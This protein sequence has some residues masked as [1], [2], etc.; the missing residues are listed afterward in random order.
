MARADISITL[1]DQPEGEGPLNFH[2]GAVVQGYVEILPHEDLQ[3]RHVFARLRWQTEGRGDRD[4]GVG[5]EQ[6]LFQGKLQSG[7]SRTFSFHLVVPD[8]PWSYAGH[9]VSIVWALE[10]M[11]DLPW[12]R[13]LRER[14][15]VVI[16]P[17]WR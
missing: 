13:D 15:P 16:A 14:M 6:D 2:P 12:S 10:V 1:R 7:L 3:C 17:A 8:Q 9:Y 4:E 5:I 11:I